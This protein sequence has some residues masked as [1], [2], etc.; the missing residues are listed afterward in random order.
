MS[1]TTKHLSISFRSDDGC[2]EHNNRDFFTDN[3]DRSRT[4]DNITYV[5]KDLHEL[6]RE[7][8]DKALAEY[9]EKQT[10]SDRMI[11]DYY[12]HIRQGKKEKLFQEIIVM[13]GNCEDCCVGSENWEIAKKMLDEY[14][15]DFEKRNPNLKVFN[16][17]MHLD[18][19]TPHLHINFVPVCYGQ[20]Q[21][22]STRVSMKRAIQ[23]M[24]FTA[25][26]KKETEAILWGNSERKKLTEIL[27][28]NHI[29]RRVVGAYHDH[30]SLNEF[31]Q[32]SNA[33]KEANA[34]ITALKKK[35]AV[36]LSEGEVEEIL[37]QNDYLREVIEKQNN[38]LKR[39]H[40]ISA[41]KFLPVE[42]YNDEKR[43]YILDQLEKVNCPFVEE[44][45]TIYIPEHYEQSVKK[46]LAAFKTMNN[47]TVRDRLKF[48]IDR[49]LYSAN[50]FEHL[51]ELL[52]Q[53]GYNI[54]SGKY[55]AVKPPYA[56]R[57]MRLRSLGEGYSE[58]ELKRRIERRNEVP[59]EFKRMEDHY[60]DELQKPFYYA[61]S[62]NITLVRTFRITPTKN[63][64]NEAYSFLND[65]TIESLC[66]CL[67][68]LSDFNITTSGQLYKLSADLQERI[69]NCADD[70]RVELKI[71]YARISSAI[72]TYEAISEGNYIDNLIRAEKERTEALTRPE[73]R[74]KDNAA[75]Q[76][77]KTT[78]TINR[79]H[80][81]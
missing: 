73:E 38:E 7:I 19:A 39:L 75:E 68:T 40:A 71:Q 29:I 18:E 81:K 52:K 9:N 15:R 50:S 24:G 55:T 46:A 14:M 49:L 16:A 77:P 69:E 23:Q 28:N 65:S 34:H 56:Q 31:K 44:N 6:Y 8:F 70:E 35:N 43:Q 60:A 20:K 45:N 30:K 33:I 64:Q 32:L 4:G 78:Q 57:F 22:L 21:G 76:Q 26:G 74:A 27:N 36:N 61:I 59:D 72:R 25:N 37:N 67:K 66:D 1:G 48:F 11:N 51:L 79:K 58:F 3:V 54:K 10:R 80:R 17:V 62:T 5:K 41:A 53:H 42:I 63:D 2:I 47:V 13:F 12:E